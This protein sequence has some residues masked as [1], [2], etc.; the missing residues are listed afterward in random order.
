MGHLEWNLFILMLSISIPGLLAPVLQSLFPRSLGEQMLLW[1]RMLYL[2]PLLF[3]IDHLLFFIDHKDFRL[4]RAI[5]VQKINGRPIIIN[6]QR[7]LYALQPGRLPSFRRRKRLP[8]LP[9][10][11]WQKILDFA[12]HVPFALDTSCEAANFHHFVNSQSYLPGPSLESYQ[13]SKS[14]Q[15]VLRL[16]CKMWK[17]L[18]DRQ[19]QY[20][21]YEGRDS[22][23]KRMKGV[24]RIDLPLEIHIEDDIEFALGRPNIYSM[25]ETP[26]T[27]LSLTNLCINDRTYNSEDCRT[28][29]L[30][31]FSQLSQIPNLRALNYINRFRQLN[32]T[33][34]EL[35]AHFASI[36]CL[37]L[38]A[39]ELLGPLHLEKLEVLYLD[40][41]AYGVT[42]WSVPNLRHLA[43]KRRGKSLF[44]SHN[45]DDNSSRKRVPIP[46]SSLR[47]LQS[48][49]LYD[50]QTI[51]TLD[52]HFWRVYPQ[53]ECI[54]GFFENF[55]I[56]DA[57]PPN[58]PLHHV[59]NFGVEYEPW[60]MR[61]HLASLPNKLPNL[62]QIHMPFSRHND[63]FLATDTAWVKL[64]QEHRQKGIIWSDRDGE[65]IRYKRVLVKDQQI[66]LLKGWAWGYSWTYCVADVLFCMALRT[67]RKPFPFN[68]S[69]FFPLSLICM[70]LWWFIS[71]ISTHYIAPRYRWVY[72]DRGSTSSPRLVP[73]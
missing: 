45:L 24:E 9:P 72:D 21:L 11:I 52:K 40:V 10:E 53:L 31:L 42:E 35:Q 5:F 49:L 58:H 2:V 70:T 61:T 73:V 3:C 60:L 68:Q 55:N 26:N 25:S 14:Q 6:S 23:E 65:V 8:S 63:S 66:P 17:E 39:M 37:H 22:L 71:H 34:P 20:W 54:G 15:K 47:N 46:A 36:T 32:F 59:V 43:V 29:I 16:V 38:E 27:L 44:P 30:H 19:P 64:A 62:R 41:F 12:I 13:H 56:L 69:I 28:A 1:S 7:L 51:L 50:V 67:W 57:P 18:L 48:L 33:L 4:R